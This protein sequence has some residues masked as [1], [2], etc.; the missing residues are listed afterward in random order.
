MT[1]LKYMLSGALISFTYIAGYSHAGLNIVPKHIVEHQM[2]TAMMKELLEMQAA[3]E[4]G[5]CIAKEWKN[6]LES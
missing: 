1:G 3:P 5:L 6:D 4:V 2:R